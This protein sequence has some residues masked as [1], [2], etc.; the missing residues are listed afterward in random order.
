MPFSV[1]CC[2][3]GKSNRGRS[4]DYEADTE[5]I[6][7]LRSPSSSVVSRSTTSRKKEPEAPK[8][9]FNSRHSDSVQLSGTSIDE[10]ISNEIG[11]GVK[12]DLGV[13]SLV[14]S[15][16]D[17]PL[18]ADLLV[19][20]SVAIVSVQ[21][22]INA[23]EI[24]KELF[25]KG[26]NSERYDDI[27]ILRF[28]LS[29][30]GNVKSA[31]KAALKTMIFREEKKLNEVGD[32]RHK[33]KNFSGEDND[34]TSN[35]NAA[36]DLPGSKLFKKFCEKEAIFN[37]LPD[38][39]RGILVIIQLSHVDMDRIVTETSAEESFEWYLY[40][41]EAFHQVLDEISRRT[42]RLTKMVQFLDMANMQLLRMNLTY[43]RRDAYTLHMMEEFYPEQI[44]TMFIFNSPEWLSGLWTLI[45]PLF[46]KSLVEKVDFLPSISKMKKS[47][48]RFGSV[49]R[50]ISEDNLPE[51]YGGMNKTWP[52]PPAGNHFLQD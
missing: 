5:I 48:I 3:R 10:S 26:C 7:D 50:C 45:R 4:E 19:A 32:L 6:P 29:H 23:N 42:G 43:A 41:H 39:N 30:R 33:I 20:H 18:I 36:N 8:Q 17:R 25:N 51:K 22:R 27:W 2:S 24:G 1:N 21:E 12:S 13:R 38:K 11:S 28:V 31:T 47:K 40:S 46:T 49:L 14:N 15:H 52:L 9:F 35:S 16:D 44:G 37:F 34:A